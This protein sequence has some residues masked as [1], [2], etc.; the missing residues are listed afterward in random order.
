MDFQ[1][2]LEGYQDRFP[3]CSDEVFRKLWDQNRIYFPEDPSSDWVDRFNAGL[4]CAALRRGKQLLIGLPDASARRSALLFATALVRHSIDCIGASRVS[5]PVIY[6]GSAIGIREQLRAV[7]IKGETIDFS[8]IFSQLDLKRSRELKLPKLK[9]TTLPKVLTVYAPYEPSEIV[10]KVAPDW[11][12]VDVGGVAD[13]PWFEEV[14]RASRE[15]GVPLI[16]WGYN[17]FARPFWNDQ[18]RLLRFSWPRPEHIEHIDRTRVFPVCPSILSGRVSNNIASS[19]SRSLN[20]L[21]NAS[22]H[23]SSVFQEE[24]LKAFWLWLR[25]LESLS[26]PFDF[27]EAEAKTYW[28]VRSLSKLRKSCT[29]FQERLQSLGWEHSSALDRAFNSLDQAHKALKLACP[30][31]LGINQ[32]L[33]EESEKANKRILVFPGPVRKE[34]FLSAMLAFNNVSEEELRTTGIRVVSLND[35]IGK[36]ESRRAHSDNADLDNLDDDS[37]EAQELLFVGYPSPFL[38][39]KILPL[40][41]YKCLRMLLYKSQ[42]VGLNRLTAEWNRRLPPN[43]EIW[44][45]TLRE[46]VAKGNAPKLGDL[47]EVLKVKIGQPQEIDIES[48]KQKKTQLRGGPFWNPVNPVIEVTNLLN[49]DS[50]SEDDETAEQAGM[51]LDSESEDSQDAHTGFAIELTFERGWRLLI[52]PDETVN[53]IVA[54]AEGR[55]IESRFVRSIQVGQE[56]VLINGQKKQDLYHLIVSR[57]HSHTS[58]Q[59]HLNLLEHW[60]QELVRNFL[61]WKKKNSYPSELVALQELLARMRKAGCDLISYQTI[62][63][64]LKGYTMAPQDPD[65]LRQIAEVLQLNFVLKNYKKVSRAATRIRSLHRQLSI[66]L[67]SWLDEE[68]S[69]VVTSGGNNVIDEELGLTFSDFRNS[70]M[71]MTVLDKN[72]VEGPFLRGSLGSPYREVQ[73]VE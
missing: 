61:A 67:N 34:L 64:W 17:C 28:G 20:L 23:T 42:T 36:W 13:L 68:V 70:L 29:L 3:G 4:V 46:L 18:N 65:H 16:G 53:V 27:L 45:E 21:V 54:T 5:K 40:F 11:I 56:I 26:V 8:E 63:N 2:A 39:H 66:R 7:K 32:L 6:F 60:H 44:E 47:D 38:T 41:S 15:N 9:D 43:P 33:F 59:L 48:G 51:T 52:P 62:G 58:F 50:F 35:L 12:A 19:L 37:S 69:E 24:T 49:L 14:V 1:V 25:N 10:K 55:T 72:R 30:L 22:H 31:W 71:I 73:D 57:V